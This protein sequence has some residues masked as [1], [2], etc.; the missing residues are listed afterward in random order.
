MRREHKASLVF[1]V[2]ISLR[3]QL[4]VPLL[5]AALCS[6]FPLFFASTLKVR[7]VIQIIPFFACTSVLSCRPCDWLFGSGGRH[8]AGALKDSP[9]RSFV[10]LL[11]HTSQHN[12]LPT[13]PLARS[14]SRDKRRPALPPPYANQ[15]GMHVSDPPVAS[16]C[17]PPTNRT[18]YFILFFW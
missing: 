6:S 17:L 4:K 13:E 12:I 10:S 3:Q 18:M 7:S 11:P 16:C 1:A 9:N 2:H 14:P 15:S 5:G 8:G